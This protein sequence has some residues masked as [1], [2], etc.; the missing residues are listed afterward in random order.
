MKDFR[1]II[2][3]CLAIAFPLSAASFDCNNASTKI[4]KTIC[5]NH[6]LNNLDE[7]LSSKYNVTKNLLRTDFVQTYTHEQREW[8]KTRN[9]CSGKTDLTNCIKTAYENRISVLETTYNQLLTSNIPTHEQAESICHDI[10]MN[11]TA[12]VLAHQILRNDFDINNDGF[13]EKVDTDIASYVDQNEKYIIPSRTYAWKD[14]WPSRVF[15][16]RIDQVTFLLNTFDATEEQPLFL[17]YINYE[18]VEKVVCD[19]KNKTMQS[20]A[21][22]KEVQG[23]D[24]LCS[25]VE[26]KVEISGD[27]SFKPKNYQSFLGEGPLAHLSFTPTLE[28]ND[29]YFKLNPL[30]KAN[31]MAL[32]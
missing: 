23:S 27:D 6:E 22:N 12:F 3:L 32:F 21:P 1:N 13:T 5:T 18:N 30:N 14:Y 2:L 4:E 15:P 16:I 19:F 9:Q 24:E 11:P 20:I 7:E 29:S 31:L 17:S 25:K 26:T 10:A 28:L 8:L